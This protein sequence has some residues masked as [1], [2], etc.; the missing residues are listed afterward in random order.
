MPD[1]VLIK[2]EPLAK[3]F[4]NVASTIHYQ[5]FFLFYLH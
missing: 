2:M 3:L 5:V 4:V 1:F